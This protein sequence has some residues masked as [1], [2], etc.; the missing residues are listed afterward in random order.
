[1]KERIENALTLEDIIRREEFW[2]RV[3]KT[4]LYGMNN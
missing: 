3:F 4:K 1:M 2:K